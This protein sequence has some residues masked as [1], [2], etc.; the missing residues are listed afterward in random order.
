MCGI[1]T[2]LNETVRNASFQN[3]D[4]QRQYFA[5]R[6]SPCLRRVFS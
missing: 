6:V 3:I 1:L 4:V 5:T 2:I